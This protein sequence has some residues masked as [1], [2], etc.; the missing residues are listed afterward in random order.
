[1]RVL[2]CVGPPPPHAQNKLKRHLKTFLKN[3]LIAYYRP[4]TL[5]YHLYTY[6]HLIII[7]LIMEEEK[8]ELYGLEEVAMV[9]IS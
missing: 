9:G 6:I 8:R 3:Q 5:Q 7:I 2:A 4:R 1:M